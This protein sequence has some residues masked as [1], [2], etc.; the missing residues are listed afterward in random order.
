M[1]ASRELVSRIGNAATV[2]TDR[3]FFRCAVCG[4]KI[5]KGENV[6]KYL[7][8]IGLET[9]HVHEKGCDEMYQAKYLVTAEMVCPEVL[10]QRA[11]ALA[12]TR[13]PYTLNT[14]I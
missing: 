7:H 13:S 12:L 10:R 9:D 3:Y 8:T 5:S 4:N 6:L 14:C 1:A 11:Y 2:A